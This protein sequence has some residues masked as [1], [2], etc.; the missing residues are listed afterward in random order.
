MV[1]HFDE[2]LRLAPGV[3]VR[4]PVPAELARAA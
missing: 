4:R 3:T 2:D 1:G